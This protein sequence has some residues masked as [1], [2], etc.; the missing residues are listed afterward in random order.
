[1]IGRDDVAA[2][3]QLEKDKTMLGCTGD[4]ECLAEIGAALGVDKLVVGQVGKLAERYVVSL[5]LLDTRQVKVESLAQETFAGSE[6]QLIGA[7]RHAGRKLL[8]VALEATGKLAVS[9]NEE[10]A[11]L[12]VDG[13]ERGLLPLPPLQGLPAGR[14]LLTVTKDGFHDWQSDVYVSP[15]ETGVVWATLEK[16][17]T[18]W[19]L[20]W[21][22]WT[23]SG[24]SAV[25][26]V[27]TGVVVGLVA[28]SI[29]STDLGNFGV[30]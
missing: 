24:A 14:H 3:I 7:V 21:W 11:T 15:D 8:G 6:E 29:P 5:R 9:S 26:I 10:D 12:L 19:Y 2:L 22:F 16:R 27:T 1:M 17:P 13:E 25:S 28:T 30:R 23:L 18:P 20:S 4:V